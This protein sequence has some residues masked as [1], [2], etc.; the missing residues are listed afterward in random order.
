[1]IPIINNAYIYF[2]VSKKLR[3]KGYCK[4]YF[5]GILKATKMVINN[6]C[7]INYASEFCSLLFCSR[8]AHP[9]NAK[10]VKKEV[11]DII[12]SLEDEN[13]I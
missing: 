2:C 6:N 4:G 9:L 3:G 11:S 10:I 5:S 1:M 13:R 8:S 12:S 7:S